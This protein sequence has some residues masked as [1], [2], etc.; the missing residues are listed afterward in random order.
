[1][2]QLALDLTTCPNGHTGQWRYK[3]RTTGR[4]CKECERE[5]ER[6]R[7]IR[8]RTAATP[9]PIVETEP[10]DPTRLYTI[11]EWH[12]TF[13]KPPIAYGQIENDL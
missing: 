5:R 1:M 10:P 3:R 12:A 11:E 13:G 8:R 7:S 6:Q 2:T 9:P 4:V